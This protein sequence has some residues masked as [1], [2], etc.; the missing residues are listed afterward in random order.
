MAGKVINHP[1]EQHPVD[2]AEEEEDGAG[3][4]MQAPN[5][6]VPEPEDSEEDEPGPEPDVKCAG[7]LIYIIKTLQKLWL[8][9]VRKRSKNGQTL[10]VKLSPVRHR[11][12]RLCVRLWKKFLL[13]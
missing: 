4:G 8:Y 7:V 5:D 13:T 1:G 12:T 3:V 2:Q 10:V 9:R 6:F 11:S